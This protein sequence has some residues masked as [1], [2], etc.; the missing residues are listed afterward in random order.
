MNHDVRAEIASAI[1]RARAPV[2]RIR[3]I[4]AQCQMKAA[5]RIEQRNLIHALGHL[6]V[7]LRELRARLAA[8]ASDQTRSQPILAG[9]ASTGVD[10]HPDNP[11]IAK[12]N[13]SRE[14]IFFSFGNLNKKRAQVL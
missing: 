4:Q 7:A 5:E 12:A 11:A 10:P 9:R 1:R 3:I 14:R 2:K 6:P 13:N 8:G